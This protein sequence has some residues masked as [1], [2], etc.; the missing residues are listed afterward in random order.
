MLNSSAVGEEVSATAPE[1]PFPVAGIGPRWTF[2]RRHPRWSLLLLRPGQPPGCQIV[3]THHAPHQNQ[4]EP[5]TGSSPS[6]K[7]PCIAELGAPPASTGGY[8]KAAATGRGHRNRVPGRRPRECAGRLS[9]KGARK[10]L[11]ASSTNSPA[12]AAPPRRISLSLAPGCQNRCLLSPTRW[13]NQCKFAFLAQGQLCAG[14][15]GQPGMPSV[16]I[17]LAHHSSTGPPPCS[18]MVEPG[19]NTDPGSWK[20]K[21]LRKMAQK[22]APPPR[23]VLGAAPTRHVGHPVPP[24]WALGLAQERPGRGGG[25]IRAR[26]DPALFSGRA[27]GSQDPAQG[28]FCPIHLQWATSR[29]W[30]L[31]PDASPLEGPGLGNP[32]PSCQAFPAPLTGRGRSAQPEQEHLSAASRLQPTHGAQD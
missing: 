15:L 12:Q 6:K 17:E 16:P 29:T 21:G 31:Q 19:A 22:E 3:E 26:S 11:G 18:V 27:G 9:A 32:P 2:K 20:E 13:G 23:R 28:S 8:S 4:P 5:P 1:I 25:Q 24:C 7:P 10:S 14:A 30:G